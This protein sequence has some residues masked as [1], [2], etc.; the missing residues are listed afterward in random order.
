MKWYVPGV[1]NWIFS[2]D[3]KGPVGSRSSHPVFANPLPCDVGLS[4]IGPSAGLLLGKT[5][6]CVAASLDELDSAVRYPAGPN[7][8]V[9]PSM[10]EPRGIE[11]VTTVPAL[12]LSVAG[13][14]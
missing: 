3:R 7:V 10:R 9:G 13:K 2:D 11:N 12:T 14:K 8:A 5:V 1:V 6:C 4:W